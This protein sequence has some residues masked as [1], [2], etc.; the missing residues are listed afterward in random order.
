MAIAWRRKIAKELGNL[1][2][3]EDQDKI[4]L[5]EE[6]EKYQQLKIMTKHAHGFKRID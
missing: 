4:V 2:T 1:N 5:G 3:R 6:H